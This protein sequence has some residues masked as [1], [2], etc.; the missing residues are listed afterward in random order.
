MHDETREFFQAHSSQHTQR[1][2]RRREQAAH[3][4]AAC[5][6]TPAL[7]CKSVVRLRNPSYTLCDLQGVGT[8]ETCENLRFRDFRDCCLVPLLTPA[9]CR[10]P[11][12]FKWSQAPSGGYLRAQVPSACVTGN[13]CALVTSDLCLTKLTILNLQYLKTT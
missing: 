2:G 12:G 7:V 6:T 11:A 8:S 1:R 10:L 9:P 13:A 4:E 5:C 3:P